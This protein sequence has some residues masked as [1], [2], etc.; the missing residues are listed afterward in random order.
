MNYIVNWALSGFRDVE[1]EAGAIIEADEHEAEKIE[2]LVKA[3]VLTLIGDVKRAAGAVDLA[4]ASA[5]E[6]VAYAKSKYG[7]DLDPA[8]NKDAMLAEIASLEAGSDVDGAGSD[9]SLADMTKAQLIEYAKSK[10]N[11]ALK[12]NLSRDAMLAEIASLEA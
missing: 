10:H 6:L 7:Y 5:D 8:L 3:G 4:A 11:F 12:M 2:E 1:H 9:T